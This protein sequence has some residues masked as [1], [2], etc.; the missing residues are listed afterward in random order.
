M[1]ETPASEPRFAVFLVTAPPTADR[2]AGAFIKV[3]GRECLLRSAELFVNRKE[4]LQTIT[5]F[6]TDT[7]DETRNKFA[8][9]LSFMG[10]AIAEPADGWMGQIKSMIERLNLEATHV[11]VHDAA[12]P[13]VP[14]SDIDALVAEVAK[15]PAKMHSLSAPIG[16]DLG[17]MD[18]AGGIL[19]YH[20]ADSYRLLVW[21][22]AFPVS[23]LDQL[24][25][26]SVPGSG[27]VRAVPGLPLN[28]R[29]DAPG[30]AKRVAAMIKLL[31][32][33]KPEGPL[34]PFADEKW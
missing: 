18:A 11:L 25:A 15:A 4:V 16:A 19:A 17:E 20:P 12:R 10:V 3:D 30:D 13:A 26:G 33:R 7:G 24:V 29:C 2:L 21:P 28:V 9:H 14:Y 5:C 34:H 23:A 6:E 22:R 8:G 32:E 1:P 27:D 31:P